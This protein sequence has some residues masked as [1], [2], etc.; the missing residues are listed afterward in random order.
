MH[1]E[2]QPAKKKIKI[3]KNVVPIEA[4]PDDVKV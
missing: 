4:L 2:E 1:I 3:I